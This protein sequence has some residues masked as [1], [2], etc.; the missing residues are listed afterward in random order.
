MFITKNHN[1]TRSVMFKVSEAIKN[2]SKILVL[3][4]HLNGNNCYYC[5]VDVC[6]ILWLYVDYMVLYKSSMAGKVTPVIR[7]RILQCNC[8][9]YPL[10]IHQN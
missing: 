10:S 8:A 7:T 2:L 3:Q 9:T 6:T 1:N 5:S 4:F